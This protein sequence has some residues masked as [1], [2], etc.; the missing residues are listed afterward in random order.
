MFLYSG[1]LPWLYIAQALSRSATSLVGEAQLISKVYFPRLILPL[2][3]TLSPLLDL[4]L[5]FLVYLGLMVWFGVTAHLAHYDVAAICRAGISQIALAGGLW[6]SALY[7]RFRDV[8]TYYPYVHSALDVCLS[9][10]RTVSGDQSGGNLAFLLRAQPCR[11]RDRGIPMVLLLDYQVEFSMFV[12]SLVVVFLALAGGLGVL[13]IDGAHVRGCYLADIVDGKPG[14]HSRC[15]DEAVLARRAQGPAQYASRS[16]DA[17]VDIP[18]QLEREPKRGRPSHSALKGVSFEVKHGEVIG[19]IGHNGAG[20]STLLKIL[21]RITEPT[22]R[23]DIY[24][25][26]SSLLEV[27]TGFHFRVVWSREY[28]SNA[29]M[30]GMRRTEVQNKF[31]DIVSFSGIEAFIDTPVK[32]YSSGMYVRLAFAVAARMNWSILIVDEVLAVGDEVF[33]SGL[34]GG[35][36]SQRTDGA[37][38]EPQHG[39]D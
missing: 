6:L 20:K 7:V 32:R 19:I 9:D 10:S 33:R 13:P 11:Q 24:G 3:G 1:L 39:R 14:N 28:R 36:E 22:G 8:G 37:Y 16:G 17:P 30:L 38:R 5:A 26:V 23:L 18:R 27:G 25:R 4:V 2:S 29:A 21:S 15:P 12:P 31:D 35:G 34:D